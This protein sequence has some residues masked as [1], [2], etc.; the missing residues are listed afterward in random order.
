MWYA[1]VLQVVSDM[2]IVAILEYMAAPFCLLHSNDVIC[3]YIILSS[4][5][6]YILFH[7]I[8]CSA[9]CGEGR[10]F[11]KVL[12]KSISP[13][14]WYLSNTAFECDVNS[15]PAAIRPCNFGPCYSKY[16]WKPSEWSEVSLMKEIYCNVLFASLTTLLF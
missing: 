13:E 14:G 15:K 9:T 3:I 6:C 4:A 5:G 16:I 7:T 8:Q 10:Q 11:R 12:C 2:R 1:D